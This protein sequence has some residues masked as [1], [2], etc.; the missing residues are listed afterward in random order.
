MRKFSA[1]LVYTLNGPPL[2]KA[3]VVLDEQGYI[4]EVIS[5]DSPGRSPAPGVNLPAGADTGS[6]A[7]KGAARGVMHFPEG[8]LV[9]GF[10]NAH[11]HLE[12]SHLK[13]AI[14]EG[15]GI[16]GFIGAINRLRSVPEEEIVKAAREAAE[17][18]YRQGISAAADIS[19]TALTADIKR[20]SPLEW[21]T[22]VETFGFH[23]S[24]AERAL[25]QALAVWQAF[26]SAGVRA[27]VV[28]HAPYS[29]S[30]LLFSGV[31]G[32]GW[33]YSNLLSIHNQESEE[34]DL[35]FRNGSGA[36][37]EHL[38]SHLGLDVSHWQPTGRSSLESTLPKLAA[39]KPLLLVHNTFTTAADLE[40]IRTLRPGNNT[41]LVLCP[42]SNLYIG[43]SLPPVPLFRQ[44][45][46][47]LCL[48]T[49]SLAS[50][51]ALSVFSEMVTLHRHFPEIPNEE[52]LAMACL[53]G[54]HALGL[55][56]RLGSLEPGKQPGLLLITP[57]PH[58]RGIFSPGS[59]ITRLA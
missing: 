55:S 12:L 56:D 59:T 29:V 15:T 27:S 1:P 30:D 6:A 54:A 52:L 48:G 16:G 35:F 32:L 57:G 21:I 9:P 42:N 36:I 31:A 49:D 53:N 13:G 24:R 18:M 11:V 2:V 8:I 14:A 7:R 50:N 51:H 45:Q 10:V 38:T 43:G 47:S 44:E 46:V 33:E 23:P 26:K 28:P 37:R 34:E 58:S 39:D 40:C 41:W 5:P 4:V 25:G 20:Q 17:E 19:N 3:T 22:L